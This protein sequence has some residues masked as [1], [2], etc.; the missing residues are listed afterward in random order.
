MKS[1][2]NVEWTNLNNA[3][4]SAGAG[5][6]NYLA[7]KLAKIVQMIKGNCQKNRIKHVCNKITVFPNV[8]LN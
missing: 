1:M 4:L 6:E 2:A 8:Q 3:N 5:L 7:R